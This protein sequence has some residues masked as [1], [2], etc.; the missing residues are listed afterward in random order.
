[1]YNKQ[2]NTIVL[3]IGSVVGLYSS[4]CRRPPPYRRPPPRRRSPS[5]PPPS[6]PGPRAS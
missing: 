4:T 3:K 2:F 6:P 5:P 1:M